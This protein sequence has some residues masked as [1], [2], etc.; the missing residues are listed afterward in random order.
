MRLYALLDRLMPRSYL[1]KVLVVA[2]L[3]GQGPMLGLMALGGAGALP[4]AVS[5]PALLAAALV[6]LAGLALGLAAVLRPVSRLEAAFAAFEAGHPPPRPLPEGHAD[7]VG[8]LM[9][10][11]ARLMR[12]AETRI[13]AAQRLAERDPLTGLLNRRG[14][15]RSLAARRRV[16]ER[17]AVLMMDLDHFKRVNDDHGHDTGD[18]VLREVADLLRNQMR[19]PDLAARFGGE[20]FVIYL[21]GLGR[22]AA[23]RVAERLRMATED[24]IRVA[25]RPQTVSIGVTPW[26]PGAPFPEILKRADGAVYAAKAAGRNCVRFAP[27]PSTAP[28]ARRGRASGQSAAQVAGPEAAGHGATA[29]DATARATAEAT[30]APSAPPAP[31]ASPLFS[32]A[33][34]SRPSQGRI[35]LR[36]VA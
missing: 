13:D 36:G 10:R 5:W 1:A 27:H 6:G 15:E 18:R 21:S 12:T 29:E 35:P 31:D 14:L 9:A 4:G 3:M 33:G 30:C 25:G 24:G 26:P 34:P 28:G 2:V 16:G 8:R 22:E 17:G 7:A 19:R 23:L 20:E 11:A 32:G